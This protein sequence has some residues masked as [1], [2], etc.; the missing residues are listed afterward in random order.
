M[1]CLRTVCSLL[2]GLLVMLQVAPACGWN[3]VG[4]L[5]AAELAYRQLSTADKAK[6]VAIR[7]AAFDD[8]DGAGLKR[9]QQDLTS[10]MPHHLSPADQDRYLFVRAATWPDMI[11]DE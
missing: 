1:P 3:D 10:G 2:L 5:L 4:H 6:A 9:F 8:P 7:K 11:R